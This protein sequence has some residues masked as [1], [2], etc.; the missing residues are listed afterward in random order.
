MQF[1]KG[2]SKFLESVDYL[3]VQFWPYGL[4]HLGNSPEALISALE[5]FPFGAILKHHPL[6]NIDYQA[7]KNDVNNLSLQK[8]TEI[9]ANLRNELPL[10][11]VKHTGHLTIICSQKSEY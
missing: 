5:E 2:A 8:M 4:R 10:D 3:I 1:F 6:P 9:M 7:I 11:N